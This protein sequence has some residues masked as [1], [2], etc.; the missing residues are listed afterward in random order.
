[1]MKH[2]TDK[3]T[4]LLKKHPSLKGTLDDIRYT[5]DNAGPYSDCVKLWSTYFFGIG[6]EERCLTLR[7]F[8]RYFNTV[9]SID[10][11]SRYVRLLEVKEKEEEVEEK[12]ISPQEGNSRRGDPREDKKY[13]RPDLT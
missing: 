13:Y 8:H 7:T 1:M 11:I 4:T 3:I 5:L 9:K 10:S 12:R 2:G 6:I